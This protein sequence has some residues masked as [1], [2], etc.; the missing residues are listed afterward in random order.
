MMRM[1]Q[2]AYIAA[3]SL[4]SK[5]EMGERIGMIRHCIS[6]LRVCVCARVGICGSKAL[7]AFSTSFLSIYLF[8]RSCDLQKALTALL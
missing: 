3:R 4:E 2:T 1:N 8:S 7:L 6:D 5:L